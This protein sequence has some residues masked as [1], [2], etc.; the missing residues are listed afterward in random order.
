MVMCSFNHFL[1]RS[2]LTIITSMFDSMETMQET[3]LRRTL[4]SSSY[5]EC[6]S[7]DMWVV[8]LCCNRIS[9]CSVGV[10]ANAGCPV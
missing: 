8:K 1:L 3:P 7:K 5:S 9:S 6:T 2:Y 4:T 10:L